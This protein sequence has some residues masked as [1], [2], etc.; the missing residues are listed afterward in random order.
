MHDFLLVS[1]HSAVPY[2]YNL[3]SFI[4]PIGGREDILRLLE[5]IEQYHRI[6][7]T[8]AE[9]AALKMSVYFPLAAIDGGWVGNWA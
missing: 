6:G 7:C 9:L 3:S 1:C 4:H 8:R 2:A 5:P